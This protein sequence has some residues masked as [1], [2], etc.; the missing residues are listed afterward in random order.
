MEKLQIKEK[1]FNDIKNQFPE[2]INIVENLVEDW[3]IKDE[4]TGEY[5]HTCKF[6]EEDDVTPNNSIFEVETEKEFN[7][8]DKIITATQ[9]EFSVVNLVLIKPDFNTTNQY[10]KYGRLTA[11][12]WGE[13]LYQTYSYY[14]DGNLN[15]IDRNGNIIFK[16]LNKDGNKE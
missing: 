5:N 3:F 7:A 12:Y 6:V 8:L 14:E 10:D 13:G 11:K 2:L 1:C 16:G 15:T 9:N 4:D